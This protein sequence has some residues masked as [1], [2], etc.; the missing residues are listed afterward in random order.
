NIVGIL[1]FSL[2][3]FVSTEF[4]LSSSSFFC[5][6]PQSEVHM[7]PFFLSFSSMSA[8]HFFSGSFICFHLSTHFLENSIQYV[9]KV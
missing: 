9:S 5:R 6:Q 2:P 1:Q 7:T 8:K 4:C 3:S